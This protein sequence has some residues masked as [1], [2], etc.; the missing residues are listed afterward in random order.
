MRRGSVEGITNFIGGLNTSVGPLNSNGITLDEAFNVEI[1]L[2]GSLR[3][4]KPFSIKT[5]LD[6]CTVSTTTGDL[7]VNGGTT[8]PGI[9]SLGQLTTTSTIYS[10]R[11][12]YW[13][14]RDIYAIII[15]GYSSLLNP[16]G[17]YVALCFLEYKDGDFS[18]SNTCSL[19]AYGG[20]F[21]GYDGGIEF[22]EDCVYL[23]KYYQYQSG[24]TL[25]S[26]VTYYVY[27]VESDRIS[28]NFLIYYRDFSGVP[29]YRSNS[30]VEVEI[31]EKPTSISA[32]FQYNLVNSGWPNSSIECSTDEGGSNTIA[33]FPD[34]HHRKNIGRFPA[35][36]NRI[37]EGKIRETSN[38][39]SLDSYSPW[40]MIKA[41]TS[42]S[43]YIPKGSVV[44]KLGGES[45]SRYAIVD[46][47]PV[48]YTDG[49][50][51]VTA[52]YK[53][54]E[55]RDYENLSEVPDASM[56]RLAE[57]DGR[58]W[59]GIRGRDF[60][61]AYSQIKNSSDKDWRSKCYQQA[62]P[63]DPISN[64]LVA[65]DGGT[66]SITGMGEVI[67]FKKYRDMIFVFCT[68]GVWSISGE[69]GSGSFLPASYSVSKVSSSTL[70][71]SE[72]IV[73]TGQSLFFL[74]YDGLNVVNMNKEGLEIV[75]ISENRV[76]SE[77]SE[78]ISGGPTGN[79]QF[80]TRSGR[81]I[82]NS[83][84]NGNAHSD[85]HT[86]IY[87]T[88]IDSFYKWEL[89]SGSKEA[90][91]F[92]LSN[93]EKANNRKSPV[94]IGATNSSGL[95]ALAIAPE[96]QLSGNFEYMP[97]SSTTLVTHSGS[98]CGL[99][100]FQQPDDK[101]DDYNLISLHDFG[102]QPNYSNTGIGHRNFEVKAKMSSVSS[103]FDIDKIVE[104]FSLIYDNTG[105]SS[106]TPDEGADSN[107]VEVFVGPKLFMK[108]SWDWS[109]ESETLS[110]IYGQYKY[111]Y[112]LNYNKNSYMIH[113]GKIPGKG[114]CL[115]IEYLIGN[116]IHTTGFKIMGHAG[117]ISKAG[118]V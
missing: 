65:T 69:G 7:F 5:S 11:A 109:D 78:I 41:S 108:T 45:S 32:Y 24:F 67:K 113:K 36:C 114:K 74:S 21:G 38:Y 29:S 107:G 71:S 54:D 89:Y 75:N 83:S 49:G 79:I 110:E 72:H 57:I 44:L 2:D 77:I 82:I 95:F 35:L 111:P 66:L 3:S 84:Y 1:G 20:I 16:D 81:V 52:V 93:T 42:K 43:N 33:T 34:M 8:F 97:S 105:Y 103:R 100:V 53:K 88:K 99:Y 14:A 102:Y 70:L 62:D 31:D 98:D 40:Q 23:P 48:S 28:D 51:T 37:Q 39:T 73:D 87:D 92:A 85:I 117:V 25:L 91:E 9:T 90:E 106:H 63:T 86:L 112:Q 64:S 56:S 59:Y 76:D 6:D 30:P 68:N 58:M 26:T 115:T 61:I 60:N 13:S 10:V 12:Y 22:G 55:F 18:L 19:Y 94:I 15:H 50:T 101:E 4:R 80:D 47:M 118:N 27:N 104:A 96:V 17:Q 116:D 46:D